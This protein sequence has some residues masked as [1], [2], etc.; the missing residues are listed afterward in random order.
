[1]E[2]RYGRELPTIDLSSIVDNSETNTCTCYAEHKR[3][4]ALQNGSHRRLSFQ[5]CTI[6]SLHDPRLAF[7]NSLEYFCLTSALSTTVSKLTRK[8]G[9]NFAN[10]QHL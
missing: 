4:R 2:A 1:M 3:D 5:H 10:S 7:R 6:S 9:E 8:L